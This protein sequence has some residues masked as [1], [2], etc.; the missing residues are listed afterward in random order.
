MSKAI[1]VF[2][3]WYIVAI[4]AVLFGGGFFL[5]SHQTSPSTPA[6]AQD[7]QSPG[8]QAAG[9]ASPAPDMASVPPHASAAA[10]T[11]QTPSSTKAAAT[12][13]SAQ[14]AAEASAAPAHNHNM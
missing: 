13:A 10:P 14:P 12:A 4:A 11:E 2:R 9:L 7:G 1:H 5:A 3:E 6:T 8:P